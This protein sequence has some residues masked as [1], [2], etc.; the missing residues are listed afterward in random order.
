MEEK[1]FENDSL[2]EEVIEEEIIAEKVDD[3]EENESNEEI[4]DG[5]TNE[6]EA[7]QKK[8]DEVNDKLVRLQAEFQ[9]YKKRTEKEKLSTYSLATQKVFEELLPIMDNMKRALD[10]EGDSEQK[11]YDGVK[12]IKKSLD[13]LFEK[14]NV[15][16]IEAT[17]E[18]FDPQKHSAML[19]EEVDGVDANIVLEEFL[20]GYTMGDRV[21]RHSMVKVSK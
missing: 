17:G 1:K 18:E 11:I 10:S 15:K 20:K 4:D 8:C 13:D 5:V 7:L 21:I 6:V 16:E 9:N 2:E 19:V 14:N 12:M 3:S